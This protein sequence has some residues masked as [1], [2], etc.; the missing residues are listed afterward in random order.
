LIKRL[1][2][3]QIIC[4]EQITY[5][6]HRYKYVTI[7]FFLVKLLILNNLG[8]KNNVVSN[9]FSFTAFSLTGLRLVVSADK[10]LKNK[11]Y[12]LLV[13]VEMISEIVYFV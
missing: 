6:E 1:T 13:F 11:I 5:I 3:E 9:H 8:K 12:K 2:T 10:D 7:I 4:K